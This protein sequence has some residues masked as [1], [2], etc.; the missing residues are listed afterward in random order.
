M[1]KIDIAGIVAV[2]QKDKHK[3]IKR[4]NVSNFLTWILQKS[5]LAL[6]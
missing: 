6:A 3:Q 1:I 4:T 2:K 5:F